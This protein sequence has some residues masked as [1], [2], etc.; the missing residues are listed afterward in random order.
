MTPDQQARLRAYA[1]RVGL[2]RREATVRLIDAGLQAHERAVAGGQ[3][4]AARMTQ[5]E[6]R[7]M[8]VAGGKASKRGKACA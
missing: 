1:R 6:R 2:T 7:E 4:R 3:A 8:S 5:E